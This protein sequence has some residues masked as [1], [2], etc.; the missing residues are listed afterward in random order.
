[1]QRG[2]LKD[3]KNKGR[4]EALASR[5]EDCSSYMDAARQLRLEE[6]RLFLQAAPLIRQQNKD[7]MQHGQQL[8]KQGQ[9]RTLK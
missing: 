8:L 2:L 6:E 9:P 7:L 1:M 4:G 3:L 5:A